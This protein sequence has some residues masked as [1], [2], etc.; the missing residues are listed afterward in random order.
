MP[1]LI[2]FAATSAAII[3]Y[4]PQIYHLVKHSQCACGISLFS[5]V[6]WLV[7]ASLLLAYALLRQDLIF[8]IVQIINVGAILTIMVLARKITKQRE[9]YG[10]GDYKTSTP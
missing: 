9:K 10:S 7:A 1:E 3:A 2:G 8:S 4:F 5:W 6:V